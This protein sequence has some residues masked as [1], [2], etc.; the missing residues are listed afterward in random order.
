M[1]SSRT[2]SAVLWR[3]FL[4]IRDQVENRKEIDREPHPTTGMARFYTNPGKHDYPLE[5]KCDGP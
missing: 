1:G 2:G 3:Q 5:G 4:S